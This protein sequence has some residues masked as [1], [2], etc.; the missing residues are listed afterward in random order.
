[1]IKSARLG[2]IVIAIALL[3]ATALP[4]PAELPE[5]EAEIDSDLIREEEQESSTHYTWNIEVRTE[6]DCATVEFDLILTIQKSD[7]D[8]ETVVRAGSVR[9]SNGSIE[10]E[11]FY[12]LE[13]ENTLARWE[14]VKSGCKPCVLNELD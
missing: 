3:A 4:V 11:M 8:E 1:M 2:T 12:E 14:V 5:C 6:E 10:H 7:G 13:P 9:L